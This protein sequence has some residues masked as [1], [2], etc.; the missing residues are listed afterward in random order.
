MSKNLR[1]C[2]LVA[3][4]V[5]AAWGCRGAPAPLRLGVDVWPG[6]DYL[7]H[8]ADARGFF[9]EEGVPVHLVE[10]TALSESRRAY[11]LGR[12]DGFAGTTVEAIIAARTSPRRPRILWVFDFSNGGD[13]LIASSRIASLAGLR[14]RNVGIE[15]GS[16]GNLLLDVALERA[17][18]GWS[19]VSL[20][21]LHQ[22]DMASA[23]RTG[24][25]DAVVTYIPYSDA[26][27]AAG[28]RPLFSSRAAPETIADVLVLDS[29]VLASRPG[30]VPALRRAL[31][32]A[33]EA[34]RQDP[35]DVLAG[36]ARRTGL[37][38][39]R[40]AA[41]RDSAGAAVPPGAQAALLAAGGALDRAVARAALALSRSGWLEDATPPTG[42]IVRDT[43]ALVFPARTRQ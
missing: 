7:L 25:V 5:A 27:L 18:L 34:A 22:P 14:G 36:A 42:L 1:S 29:V 8:L 15:S 2:V 12:V 19:D 24:R 23:V 10:F 38:A 11:E 35:P 21:P 40:Y 32:R 3:V 9:A 28:G 13:V 43:T 4:A 17:G 39:A 30:V 31:A 16:A 6:Y 20:V 33:W 37:T 41:I 26:V